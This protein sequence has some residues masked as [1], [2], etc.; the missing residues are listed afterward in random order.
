[1]KRGA[2]LRSLLALPLVPAAITRLAPKSESDGIIHIEPADDA[3]FA[4]MATLPAGTNNLGEWQTDPLVQRERGYQ[5]AQRA[6][7]ARLELEDH[8]FRNSTH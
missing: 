1:M 2:F 7:E 5:L 3:P 6:I 4:S 8:I